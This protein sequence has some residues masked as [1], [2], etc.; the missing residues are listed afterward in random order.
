MDDWASH[1]SNSSGFQ[2]PGWYI[3]HKEMGYD[4]FFA[5]KLGA[6]ALVDP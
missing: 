1:R 6:G 4:V 2:D 3:T 5:G